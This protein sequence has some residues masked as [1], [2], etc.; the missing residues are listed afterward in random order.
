MG[1]GGDYSREAIIFNIFVKG[2]R[3]IKGRLLFKEIRYMMNRTFV[4][5]VRL[6]LLNVFFLWFVTMENVYS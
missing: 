3:L 5:S 2:G 4:F 6:V 1:G